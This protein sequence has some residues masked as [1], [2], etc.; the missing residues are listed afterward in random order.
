M[1]RAKIFNRLTIL[2][3]L[4]TLE[5]PTIKEIPKHIKH[6]LGLPANSVV[7]RGANA[8]GQ[9]DV[10]ACAET[11]LH[12]RNYVPICFRSGFEFAIGKEFRHWRPTS[13]KT[14]VL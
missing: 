8:Y 10:L 4:P 9:H 13:S 3:S 7:D 5:Q 2:V 6:K 14:M 12:L 11:D 1:N